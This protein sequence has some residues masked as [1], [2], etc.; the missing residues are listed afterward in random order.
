MATKT[1]IKRSKYNQICLERKKILI[2]SYKNGK[3]IHE[4]A[5]NAEINE[6]TAKSIIYK[7]KKDN[8]ILVASSRG[9]KRNFKIN[10]IILDK[11]EKIVEENPCITLKM[12]QSKISN[13]EQIQLCLAS[14]SNAL[15]QLKI[16]LK[17]ASMEVDRRNSIKTLEE[18][19]SYALHYSINAPEEREMNIFIDESGFNYHLRRTMARSKINTPA[20]V[21]L[22]TVRGRNISLIAAIN[23]EGVIFHQIITQSNV[24]SKIFCDFLHELINKLKDKNFM[25]VWLILDNARIH[26]TQEVKD[27]V[28]NTCHE[29]VFL[30]SYSPMMN[31]IEEMFSKVKLSARNILADPTRKENLKD[32]IEQSIGTIT[33]MDCYNFYMSMIKKLP[34]AAAQNPL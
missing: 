5:I 29:L 23:I 30:P 6:N 1:F 14:I 34:S 33:S 26:K 24:N 16:T 19:K 17:C 27:L 25:K 7:F 22:P 12:I 15:K 11:I 9:G 21:I 2:N 8:D 10:N 32:V 28:N 18:R 31:P 13:A 4:S 20:K 3:T